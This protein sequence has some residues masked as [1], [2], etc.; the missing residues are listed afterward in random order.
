MAE[1]SGFQ[2]RGASVWLAAHPESQVLKKAVA[3]GM[4]WRECL[5]DRR[6]LPFDAVRLAFWLRKN[7][8]EVVNTHSSRDGWLFGLAARL[9][10]TPMLIRSRHIDV[11][12]PNAW[13]SRHAFT[14]FAD[15]VLTTSQKITD[16]FQ[17]IFHLGNDHITTLPT[18]I[19]LSRYHLDGA[20][21]VLPM[22]QD[23]GAPPV[24]GMVSVLRSWKGHSVFFDAVRML[25]QAGHALQFI[26]VGGGAPIDKYTALARQHGAEQLVQ[27]TGHR[28]DIPEV[29]RA[30]DVLCIPSVRHEGVPQIG[31]QALA[32]GTSVVGSDCGG[33]P[34]IIQEGRTGRIF[35]AG[36]AVKLASRILETFQDTEATNRMI[37]EGRKLVESRYNLDL[38]LDQLETIYANHLGLK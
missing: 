9:A 1:L 22:N 10:R 8:I 11:S 24:V 13:V 20:K 26:V 25:H 34:E 15:H 33:I 35:P 19:D 23:Q 38:M 21:A 36:D 30:I 17:G 29:L 27:F 37:H 14:T 7:R 3:A 4:G 5:F 28:E 31:L 32:S 18:G 12:Y 6:M 16:H 2:R